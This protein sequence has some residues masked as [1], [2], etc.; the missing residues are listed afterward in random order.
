VDCQQRGQT[1]ILLS[2]EVGDGMNPGSSPGAASE[3]LFLNRAVA[4][5]AAIAGGLKSIVQLKKGQQL[6]TNSHM[7]FPINVL[8]SMNYYLENGFIAEFR[9]IGR[10]GFLDFSSLI[11]G[12]RGQ[13]I[14]LAQTDGDAYRIETRVIQAIFDTSPRFRRVTLEYMQA[15]MREAA[16]NVVCNRFHSITQQ[17]CFAL[18]MAADRLGSQTIH[19]THEQLAVAVG[20]RREAISIVAR[21]LQLAGLIDYAY[22]TIVIRDANAMK[23]RSCEC[24]AAVKTAFSAFFDTERPDPITPDSPN[25]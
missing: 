24:Y 14:A 6:A 17:V 2:A 8:I 4:D 11:G 5:H 16:Q 15:L 12:N 18:L 20:C 1:L 23:V 3:N 25:F 21:K 19:L 9:Q 22:G 10:E 7:F 13:A